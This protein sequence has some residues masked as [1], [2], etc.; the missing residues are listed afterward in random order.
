M[1]L[2]L[3]LI[4]LGSVIISYRSMEIGIRDNMGRYYTGN[5]MWLMEKKDALPVTKGLLVW[6]DVANGI[7]YFKNKRTE[8]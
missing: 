8:K 3:F 6:I 4:F 5:G 1:R 7:Y 2:A